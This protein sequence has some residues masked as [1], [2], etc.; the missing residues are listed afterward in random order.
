MNIYVVGGAKGIP[1]FYEYASDVFLSFLASHGV[2]DISAMTVQHLHDFVCFGLEEYAAST[3]KE[4]L[5][6]IRRFL[7][8]LF[9]DGEISF[10]V[11]SYLDCNVRV[12]EKVVSVLSE[13]QEKAIVNH[14]DDNAKDCR[15]KAIALCCLK[16]G[17]RISDTLRLRFKD[18]N[19]E[20][21]TIGIVQLKTGVPLK[22][23]LPDAVGN[24]IASY[25][26]L[27][28]PESEKDFIFLTL[29]APYNPLGSSDRGNIVALIGEPDAQVPSGANH[30]LRRTCASDM[31][32]DGTDILTI[33]TVLGHA[34]IASIDPYLSI[35]Q[36]NMSDTPLGSISVP[37]PEV[38][39]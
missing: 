2:S 36:K 12:P 38:L 7:R 13:K 11:L 26:C 4:M 9:L 17:L 15:N 28:R 16:L 10:P 29:Q 34:D 30:L 35:D 3:K 20:T 25:V 31:L 8:Y 23:P 33:S 32:R 21:K 24:A 14:S 5:Y 22:L 37:L 18:I 19:W 1:P 27:F 6:R 39:K